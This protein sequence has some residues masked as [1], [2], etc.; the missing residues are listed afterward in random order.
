MAV[1]GLALWPGWQNQ[2]RDLVGMEHVSAA[3]LGP[4]VAVTLVL[5]GLLFLVGRLVGHGGAGRPPAG[6]PAAR[7]LAHGITAA[8][9][10]VAVVL[11]TRDVVVDG[12]LDWANKRFGQYDTT[13]APGVVAPT[14]PTASGSLASLVLATLGEYGRSFVATAT[15]AELRAFHGPA[16]EVKRPIRVYAGLRSAGTPDERPRAVRELERTGAFQRGSW[17]SSPPPAPAGP[18]PNAASSV[19]YLHGGDTALV[20]LQYSYPPS[21][22]SFLVDRDEAAEAGIA[23]YRH[24]HERW[25]QL[26][27]DDRPRL[28]VFGE[29]LGSFG[30]EAGMG[31]RRRG[32]AGQAGR[33]VGRGAVHRPRPP[34]TS[35]TSSPTT[36]SR[37][38]PCGARVRRRPGA[39]RQP[40]RRPGAP[41]PGLAAP[42]VLYVHHPRT[43]SGT[44]PRRH[45][46][47]GRMDRP[48]PGLRRACPGR[49]VP[50]RHRAP[51]GLRP[52]RRLQ[53][54]PPA[55]GTTTTSTS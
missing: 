49:L 46:G 17:A 16:A 41:R 55:T 15:P 44:R 18:D 5:F 1:A 33:R 45:S 22:I 52:D 8:V 43:R 4:M 48:A 39:V 37:A 34:A 14:T 19:E 21:W 9:L 27:A 51:G 50:D 3:A 31:R 11:L 47:G 35:G 7:L 38:P 6:A 20:G 10:V 24:V 23:L 54:P 29:S 26:P 28:L 32:L 13:T 25:S 42:R 30:A 2:Q 53:R 36:G 12:F 40:A